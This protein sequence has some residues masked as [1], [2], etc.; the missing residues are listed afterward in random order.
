MASALL[1][2]EGHEATI[3][4]STVNFGRSSECTFPFPDNPNISRLHAEISYADG[5]YSVT[6]LGS[7]NGTTINGQPISGPTVLNDGDFIT[8][9]N[10]VI[11]EILI[12]DSGET[13]DYSESTA[14]ESVG[15]ASSPDESK[16][17][18][19][20]MLGVAGA[21]T[22]IA[23]VFAVTAGYML[24][25]EDP[26]AACNAAAQIVSPGNGDVLSDQ[27]PV[28]ISVRNA[29]CVS[30]VKLL[31]NGQE[32][33][34]LDRGP[35]ET[36][37]DPGRFPE[38]SDGGL[39]GLTVVIEDLEG[40]NVPQ[41]N[42]VAVQ[43][44]TRETK[45]PEPKKEAT[46]TPGPTIA[47]QRQPSLIEIERMATEL[48]K[49]F[50]A[51]GTA[52]KI[53]N[54]DFL[55]DVRKYSA[56]Y[57]AAQGYFG[58]AAEFKD[59]INLAFVRERSLDPALPYL[60]A[61]SRSRFKLDSDN[62]DGLWKMTPQLA[63]SGAYDVQCAPLNLTD[64]A[65]ECAARVAAQY[66]QDLTVQ[67]FDGDLILTAAAFGKTRQDALAWKTSLPADR[68]DFW[69]AINTPAEREQ[70][71]RFFAAAIVAENPTRFGLKSD[72]PIS[73][74]YPPIVR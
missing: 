49:K 66:V 47:G 7:S 40:R 4:E 46:V 15:G 51:T 14:A 12:E 6:D 32:I 13:D 56:E 42:E 53:S 57:G 73:E 68:T 35:Y 3:G 27:T 25:K 55:Q 70:I 59:T 63:A 5:E 31:L 64:A 38:L 34:R 41:G 26:K 30:S 36:E 48:V 22:G 69:R 17:K 62:G 44:E 19:P 24:L 10:S 16:R 21:I 54:P 71:A 9:G 29:E 72:R 39:H 8:I 52:Y 45:T 74:H 60:L 67:T 18:S 65:Q 61:M 20:A 43:F 28:L 1:K 58:R 50:P 23:V 33:A 37:I 2:F 11:I